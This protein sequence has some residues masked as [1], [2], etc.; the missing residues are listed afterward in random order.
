MNYTNRLADDENPRV[1]LEAIRD[2]SFFTNGEAA[3]IALLAL[4]HPTDYYI[5]YT[6]KETIHQL[7]PYWRKAI[8]EGKPIAADNAAGFNYLVH[9]ISTAELL[10]MPHTAVV[11]EAILTRPD[12][13]DQDRMV[14]LMALR[15]KEQSHE[16]EPGRDTL[17]AALDANTE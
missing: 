5:D 12:A 10:K 13:Q 1:R 3:N 16:S 17:L 8:A 9:S 15:Q 2:L 6:L 4:K 14:A 7:E 11:G